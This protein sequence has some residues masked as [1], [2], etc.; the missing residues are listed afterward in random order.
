MPLVLQA[1]GP[2]DVFHG[3]PWALIVVTIA[4]LAVILFRTRGGGKSDDVTYRKETFLSKAEVLFL[5]SL[6]KSVTPQ[7][8]VFAQVPLKTIVNAYSD[9][10]SKQTSAR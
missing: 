4:A 3:T 10:R 1:F 5:E 9:D 6:E 8:R 7:F 2:A